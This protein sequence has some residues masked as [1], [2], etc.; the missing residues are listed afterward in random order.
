MSSANPE[1]GRGPT[2]VSVLHD[3]SELKEREHAALMART[4]AENVKRAKEL[5][6]STMSHELRTPVNAII[7]FSDL[8]LQRHEAEVEG[9]RRRE[10][11]Q[12]INDCGQHML[13]V[14]DSLLEM[15]RM[16]TGQFPI[17]PE[18]LALA[19]MIA[20][21]CELLAPKAQASGIQLLFGGATPC[22]EILADKRAIKQVLLNLV[23]NAL[24]FTRR[25]G[26]VTVSAIQEHSSA[27]I[28]V[29]DTGVGIPEPDLARLGVPFFQVQSTRPREG[30]G[31]GL[32]IVKSLISLH[33]GTIDITSRLGHGTRVAVRLPAAGMPAVVPGVRAEMGQHR[34]RVTQMLDARAKKSA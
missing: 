1:S 12:L 18:P 3:L 20:G 11:T 2:V 19:P 31:L 13:A 23:T 15:S 28:M 25:G 8:L 4:E 27:L 6:L 29:A 7:G 14:V 17:A 9:A 26:E 5:L 24:K 21:C 16:G 34:E 30:A 22:P 10:Y 32:A 33:G